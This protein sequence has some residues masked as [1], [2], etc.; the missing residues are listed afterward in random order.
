MKASSE[1]ITLCC[2]KNPTLVWGPPDTGKTGTLGAPLAELLHQ[3]KRI[4]VTSTTNAA[5]DLALG[6]LSEHPVGRTSY[7]R[8]LVVRL[9]QSGNSAPETALQEI[10]AALDRKCRERLE[11]IDD[12]LVYLNKTIYIARDVL[13]LL[14]RALTEFQLNLFAESVPTRTS[15]T[16]CD[17]FSRLAEAPNYRPCPPNYLS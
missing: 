17:P 3:G 15:F 8:H 6:Q 14:E 10:V 5:V 16:L 11:A 13:D 1:P 4:L 9:G 7:D 12:R 2:Q